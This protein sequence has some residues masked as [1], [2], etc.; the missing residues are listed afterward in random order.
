MSLDDTPGRVPGPREMKLRALLSHDRFAVLVALVGPL[1][2]SAALV[3]F[4]ESVANANV[5]LVLVLVIV[6]VAGSGTRVAGVLAALSSSLW[7]DLFLTRP[8]GRFTITDRADLETTALLLAVGV[9]VTELALW[10]R[11][12]HE[13]ANREAG[14]LAGIRAAAEAVATGGSS[15]DLIVEVTR[16]LTRLFD[17]R[18]CRFQYGVAGLGHPARLRDDGGVEWNRE[19]WDVDRSGLPVDVDI[20]LL[21]ESGGRLQGRFL[22][23][24]SPDTHASMAQRL[25]AVTLASQVGASLR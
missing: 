1:A 2:V 18:E 13:N 12:Q 20:E 22:F 19:E 15:A 14:Y 10:G 8:Y 7:F 3:P 5:A 4:R 21:V 6:A 17:L 11:R 25:V 16:Q 9:G 23:R 24:A